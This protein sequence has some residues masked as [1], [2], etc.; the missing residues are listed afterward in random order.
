VRYEN[1]KGTNLIVSSVALGTGVLASRV[2]VNLSE[3]IL[4]T[5]VAGGGTFIDTANSY[6]RWNP[7]GE[8]LSELLIGRWMKK[9]RLRDKV[10]LATKGGARDARTMA[11]RLSVET[12]R[13]DLESSLKS[14]QTDYV[15]LYY[16]HRDNP[17]CAVPELMDV[18]NEFKREGKV[19]YF[20]VSNWTAARL[21]E[22]RQYCGKRGLEFFSA[23][24]IMYNLAKVND[25]EIDRIGQ[26]HAKPEILDFHMETKMPMLAYSSQAYGIF[27][28]FAR[29]DFMTNPKFEDARKM[30]LNDTTVQRI[31]RVWELAKLR[32]A[33]P[34][35]IALGYL[36]AHPF[37]IIPIV[38]PWHP[39]E[40]TESLE[41]IDCRLSKEEVEF[42]LS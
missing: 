8:P 33:A 9:H 12:I 7:E 42:L 26:S 35:Q 23:D 2:E 22:A 20:A 38:G 41:S 32:G 31:R 6:G 24:E 10:V 18:L 4:D 37:Q 30:Y 1:L 3:R 11:A 36:Y 16:L 25:E 14:L 13:A 19:R 28:T 39:D 15:D 27:K 5:F 29:E 21:R 17:A 34:M 40:L